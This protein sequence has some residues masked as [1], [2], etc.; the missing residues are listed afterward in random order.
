[1]KNEDIRLLLGQ[2]DPL[3]Q[4]LVFTLFLLMGSWS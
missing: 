3:E 2:K 4:D 1:M